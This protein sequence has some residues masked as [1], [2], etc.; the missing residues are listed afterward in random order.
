MALIHPRIMVAERIKDDYEK[1]LAH[2]AA[3]PADAAD[4]FAAL[5]RKLV[6]ML[7]GRGAVFPD[8]LADE[9]LARVARK[10]ADGEIIHNLNAYSLT[11]ARLVW[12]EDVRRR[13][14]HSEPLDEHTW[15]L[16]A[17]NQIVEEGQ[18]KR[19]SCLEQCLTELPAETRLLIVEYYADDGRDLIQR[20]QALATRL[21]IAREAL[22]NRAQRLRQKLES[23]ITNCVQRQTAI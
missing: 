4:G 6:R 5:R 14:H 22:A 9:T 12:L 21:G 10:L 15:Q 3:D 11:I 7:S 23:C 17:T 16:P 20:R 13:A 19:L 18:E 2:F 8:D 1:L